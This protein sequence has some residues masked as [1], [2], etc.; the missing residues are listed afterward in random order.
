VAQGPNIRRRENTVHGNRCR[1]DP[2][3]L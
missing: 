1:H 2:G 3:T